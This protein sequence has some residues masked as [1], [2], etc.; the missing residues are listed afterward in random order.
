MTT[1]T[2]MA[3]QTMRKT[4]ME[5]ALLILWT[6]MGTM[7]ESPTTKRTVME[8]EF[9]IP[10]IQVSGTL[11]LVVIAFNSNKP[12]LWL[13]ITPIFGHR[14]FTAELHDQRELEWRPR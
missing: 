8:M 11:Q 13:E 12:E 5:M 10:S 3:Y 7:T 1:L 14:A 9:Q 2:M 6:L 4:L